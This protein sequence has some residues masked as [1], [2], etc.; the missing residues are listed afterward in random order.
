MHGA[1]SMCTFVIFN[2]KELKRELDVVVQP[3]TLSIGMVRLEEAWR[4]VGRR[5]ERMRGR[6]VGR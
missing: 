4:E 2:L 3:I 5:K 1:P 6:K